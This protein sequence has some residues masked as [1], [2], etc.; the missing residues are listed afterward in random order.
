AASSTAG[1]TGAQQKEKASASADHAAAD[2]LQQLVSFRVAKEEFAFPMERVREILR[3]ETP[4]KVPNAPDSVL[5]VLTVR[6]QL[7]P[8]IDLRRQLHLQS[9]ADEHIA[10]SGVVRQAF[11]TWLTALRSRAADAKHEW[12]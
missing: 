2:D 5:G 1:A 7:L 9:M 12:T 6:G 10:K 4:T 3:V 8:I 11:E